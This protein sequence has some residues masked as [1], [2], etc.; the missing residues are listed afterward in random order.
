MTTLGLL[1][2]KKM[3]HE[4]LSSFEVLVHLDSLEQYM[5]LEQALYVKLKE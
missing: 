1:V 2:T 5:Y 4:I 3:T